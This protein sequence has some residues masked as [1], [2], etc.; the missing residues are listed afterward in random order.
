MKRVYVVLVESNGDRDRSNRVSQEG[1]IR[2]EDAYNFVK[3]R[4]EEHELNGRVDWYHDNWVCCD[5]TAGLDYTIY[6][7]EVIK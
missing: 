2:W 1:Y 3:S 5:R 6:E 4:V 7:V